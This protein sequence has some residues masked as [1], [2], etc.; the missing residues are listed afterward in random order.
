MSNVVADVGVYGVYGV[1]HVTSPS[2]SLRAGLCEQ[3]HT[4]NRFFLSLLPSSF[5]L[6]P[7][8]GLVFAN[9]AIPFVGFGIIDNAVMIMAGDYID[10]TIGVA[11]GISTMAA[12]GLGKSVSLSLSL[13]LKKSLYLYHFACR[14]SVYTEK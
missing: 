10:C 7:P 2:S 9:N 12:A 14:Y 5:F 1:K 4:N 11:L 8:S 6:L 13:S 3:C